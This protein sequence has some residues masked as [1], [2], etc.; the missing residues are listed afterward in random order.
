MYICQI[1]SFA[2]NPWFLLGSASIFI[3]FLASY[4]VFLSSITG[5]LLCNY[6]IISR[7]YFNMPD[8]FV[9]KKT[10]N[11]Y[12]TYGWNYRAYIAYVSHA[13]IRHCDLFYS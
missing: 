3:S 13:V 9:A 11:Y 2:I 10:G 4:Q 5:V 12:Y 7:G 6:W 1:I 8:L